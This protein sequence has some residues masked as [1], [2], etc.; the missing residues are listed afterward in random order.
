[1]FLLIIETEYIASFQGLKLKITVYYSTRTITLATTVL[2]IAAGHWP[3]SDQFH[4]LT[5]H[6]GRPN[7]LYIFN[8]TAINNLQNV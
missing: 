1:M 4:H 8:G 7:L 3:F 2:E 5:D 6:F